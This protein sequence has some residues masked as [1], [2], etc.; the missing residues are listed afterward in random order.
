MPSFDSFRS[1][2]PNIRRA[3][4]VGN[5]D[6][7]SPQQVTTFNA[8]Q[9]ML[10][11][12]AFLE[13][14]QQPAPVA[15][16]QAPVS[17]YSQGATPKA[18]GVAT[19]GKPIYHVQRPDGALIPVAAIS[20]DRALINQGGKYISPS[21]G[22]RYLA[23]PTSP[24]GMR[25]IG[26]EADELAAK[27][28][29]K[30]AKA[31][32]K[33][34]VLDEKELIKQQNNEREA[35]F[36]K[37]KRPNY[38]DAHGRIQPVHT[39]E[40][41]AN[42]LKAKDTAATQANEYLKD[43]RRFFTDKKTGLPVPMTSDEE[44]ERNKQEKAQKAAAAPFKKRLAELDVELSNPDMPKVSEKDLKDAKE[45]IA[46]AE[47]SLIEMRGNENYDPLTEDELKAALTDPAKERAA[48][49]LL[50]A[51][52]QEKQFAAS[53]ESRKKL[54]RE[55]YEIKKRVLDPIGYENDLKAAVPNA[56]PE[57]LDAR[58]QD[59]GARVETSKAD[60]A[61]KQQKLD[62]EEQRLTQSLQIAQ[63]RYD[64]AK[65]SG[66]PAV[67]GSAGQALQE[68]EA[69]AQAFEERSQA[70][71]DKLNAEADEVNR[72]IGHLGI[73]STERKRRQQSEHDKTVAAFEQAAPG[74]G[75]EYQSL[76][77][78]GSK[79]AE[80]LRKK[81]AGREESPEAKAAFK[82]LQDDITGKAEIIQGAAKEVST[83][84]QAGLVGL[85]DKFGVA[86]SDRDNLY[87]W[88]AK[89]STDTDAAIAKQR[90]DDAN[91]A[92]KKGIP[93]YSYRGEID[94]QLDAEAKRLGIDP[95]EA[96]T[97]METRRRLDWSKPLTGEAME[98]S[99]E[100]TRP[101]REKLGITS[102][103]EP[104][105]K[106][107]DGAI[108][109]NPI[110]G[111]D[112]EAFKAAIEA[113]EGTPAQKAEALKQWPALRRMYGDGLL[114]AFAK[115]SAFGEDFTE[116]RE[117]GKAKSTD[118][119][120]QALQY[121]DEMKGR[122]IFRRWGD[123]IASN[124]TAGFMDVTQA[125]L[126]SAGAITGSEFVSKLAA[127]NAE[128]ADSLVNTQDQLSDTGLAGNIAATIARMAPGVAATVGTGSLAGGMIF[129]GAQTAGMLYGDAYGKLRDEG[130]SHVEAWKSAAPASL[131]AGAMTAALTKIFP[132]GT[133]AMLR[134]PEARQS[135][136]AM[137]AGFL[138]SGKSIA[139][140]AL[141]E[142][143][144]ELIDEGVSQMAQGMA[145]GRD[146]QQ[147]V[148]DFITGLPELVVASGLMG[149]GMQALKDRHD[150]RAGGQDAAATAPDGP[151]PEDVEG[152]KAA[153]SAFNPTAPEAIQAMPAA[154]RTGPK[155]Q[156]PSEIT[157]KARAA[158]D[159]IAK[160]SS[161][162]KT[163]LAD[164][165][166]TQLRGLG[167]ARDKKGQLVQATKDVPPLASQPVEVLLREFSHFAAQ[168]L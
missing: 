50:A 48:K 89:T 115:Q 114:T 109:V 142:I 80:A 28:Q 117:S 125:A 4:V 132:G 40:E 113:T 157:A 97:Y 143:P 23:D 41:W 86:N 63:Q 91:Y 19:T 98:G 45:A 95:K 59:I 55:A 139:K 79:R 65:T 74:M 90:A 44:H 70:E 17:R 140:G 138:S 29:A 83:K 52:E 168:F 6:V 102:M 67:L 146:P 153:I 20:G 42:I 135:V 69:E 145:E 133:Q 126:G 30:A 103:Q 18:Q 164:L 127:A 14:R 85:W 137:V 149:G 119:V 159:A 150:R 24:T 154:I 129:G 11:N 3:P 75:R 144:E 27:E 62:A 35:V 57:E 155:N 92:A 15:P 82:A 106:L 60:L 151:L 38:T 76:V 128:N 46:N 120:E 61:A 51:R 156:L 1:P 81:Y 152:I 162:E 72:D 111:G 64:E 93:G 141:D 130:K 110:L 31:Q 161:G 166:D 43:G 78:D 37:E 34:D 88:T 122:S 73:I 66:N 87:D 134:S 112:E 39:D 5:G 32:A 107:P 47:A 101:L 124:V 118:P 96:R 158:M 54:E 84:K 13:S 147:V 104:T 105:R 131:A 56:S 68:L 25:D 7:L 163:K 26:T 53:A 121:Q 9:G 123:L 136:R 10:R 21:T 71:R 22:K 165:T 36:T 16:R 108:L 167:Y 8:S 160:V 94:K 148:R 33:V 99:Q 12:Q 2:R 100:L 49:E 58:E 77:D 116:W